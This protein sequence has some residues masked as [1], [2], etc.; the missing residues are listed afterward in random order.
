[1]IVIHCVLVSYAFFKGEGQNPSK[2]KGILGVLY[3]KSL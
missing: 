2:K 1:M 3:E